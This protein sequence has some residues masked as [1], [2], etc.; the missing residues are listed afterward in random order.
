MMHML[1]DDL[2]AWWDH[3]AS[4]ELAARY[5]QLSQL[6][7]KSEHN[8]GRIAKSLHYRTENLDERIILARAI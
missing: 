2:G 4:F 3:I 6:E 1:I 7:E 5:A 8:Q